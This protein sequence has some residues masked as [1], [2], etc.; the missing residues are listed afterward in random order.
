MHYVNVFERIERDWEKLRPSE[1]KVA[2]LVLDAPREV[3]SSS[4]ASVAQQAGISEP[5]V[6]RFC[7]VI[8]F[9]GF[10]EFKLY[11]AQSLAK[12]LPYLPESI[13]K[14]DDIAEWQNWKQRRFG[15]INHH[16]S[17]MRCFSLHR[18][19]TTG[20][21]I[22]E[23]C[24]KGVPQPGLRLPFRTANGFPSI[25]FQVLDKHAGRS[26]RAWPDDVP[27]ETR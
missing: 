2:Q 22:I 25:R 20:P 26:K 13:G 1:R 11:L 9:A 14:D 21:T 3:V 5:S 4:I 16:V 18:V 17:P 7:T 8:G 23:T 19:L 15:L 10:Q 24:T 12:D 27:C 6:M